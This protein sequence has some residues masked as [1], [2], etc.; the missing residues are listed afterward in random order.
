VINPIV[1][2]TERDKWR[3]LTYWTLYLALRWRNDPRRRFSVRWGRC[4][5]TV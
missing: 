3:P 4:W 5:G 1:Y 2:M